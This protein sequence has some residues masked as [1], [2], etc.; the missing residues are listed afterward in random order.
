MRTPAASEIHDER[1]LTP[2]EAE[3]KPGALERITH[4]FKR[5]TTHEEWPSVGEPYTGPLAQTRRQPE[6]HDT[7]LAEHVNVYAS[8]RS[9]QPVAAVSPVPPAEQAPPLTTIATTTVAR[10]HYPA[11]VVYEGPLST[12]R[13][14]GELEGTPLDAHVTAYHPGRSDLEEAAPMT[15]EP[16]STRISSLF[17]RKPHHDDFPPISEPFAGPLSHTARMAEM[18]QEPIGTVVSVYSTGRSDEQLTAPPAPPSAAIVEMEP[19]PPEALVVEYPRTAPY[20]GPL[21]STARNAELHGQPLDAHVAAYHHGR[22]DIGPSEAATITSKLTSI[23]K[24]A[25]AHDDYPAISEQFVGPMAHTQRHP[26]LEA[27][28]V[29]EHVQSIQKG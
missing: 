26:E 10:E 28:P 22:S 18:R 24:K 23:F 4:L 19:S 9:D 12:T 6:M 25:A 3:K 7:S 2:S 15:A 21:S 8:G 13:R 20:E 27:V 1:E 16:I 11:T 14:H 29:Q 17:R 5:S